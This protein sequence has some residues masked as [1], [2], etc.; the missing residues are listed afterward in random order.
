MT[1]MARLPLTSDALLDH[2]HRP[3]FSW[4]RDCS[5]GEVTRHLDSADPDCGLAPS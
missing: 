2:E 1:C 5:V 3:D 4:W